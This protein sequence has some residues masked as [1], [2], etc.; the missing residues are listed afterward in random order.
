M[1]FPKAKFPLPQTLL[2]PLV[3][4]AWTLVQPVAASHAG[5]PAPP[6]QV[7]LPP[8]GALLRVDDFPIVSGK[9]VDPRAAREA[10]FWV[11][12]MLAHR[13]D[14]RR[15]MVASGTRL[16]ILGV[17]EFTCDAPEFAWLG[18]GPDIDGVAAKDWWDARARGTGGSATD[19]VCS[20]GE[21]N[22]L[23]YPGD[24]YAAE[25]ILLHE[26]AHSVHLRGMNAVDPGFD[27]RVRQAYDAARAAGLWRGTYASTN[28]AEYFAEG[29]Q[30]WFDDNRENDHDHNHVDT[31]RELLAYDPGL[32][33][34]CQEVFGDKVPPY[35]K[36]TTRLTGHLRGFD[37][38]KAP[39][40]SWPER[41][42]EVQQ[43]IRAGAQSRATRATTGLAAQLAPPIPTSDPQGNVRTTLLEGWTVRLTTVG[44]APSDE[45]IS[46]VLAQLSAELRASTSLLPPAA[47]ARLRT[48]PIIIDT[49]PTP[50]G[51]DASALTI[52]FADWVNVGA[53]KPELL[54]RFAHAWWV[55]VL[56]PD[57]KR[58]SERRLA[59]LRPG[60]KSVTVE[61]SCPL[62]SVGPQHS[63][64]ETFCA[65][66]VLLWT[67][68]A[69][70]G[71]PSSGSPVTNS[72]TNPPDITKSREPLDR[73]AVSWLRGVWGEGT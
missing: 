19:P 61:S 5:L 34:L 54:H 9:G 23:G 68:P 55:N 45:A 43:K 29:A 35:S 15:A 47:V 21:E 36:P 46:G 14:V 18:K 6:P 20:V 63:T 49:R 25:S 8:G 60:L 67:T 4:I 24:P 1:P 42:R 16:R 22:V 64:E 31:R 48:F 3:A 59:A 65:A 70:Q 50:P 53:S 28:P 13:P 40:F 41:L 56:T 10:A 32:A 30:S 52:P 12:R 17:G 58:E 39:R 7:P 11:R 27:Q 26:F 37:P 33:A 72:G 38:A 71:L 73:R 2:A 57:Q 66:S 62:G 44:L 69:M 51:P